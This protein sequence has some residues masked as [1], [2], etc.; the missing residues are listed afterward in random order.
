MWRILERI[1]NI[2]KAKTEK[3]LDKIE[4]PVEM[5]RLATIEFEQAINKSHKALAEVMADL[6]MKEKTLEQA[7]FTSESWWDKAKMAKK[8]GN[9]ELAAKALEQKA[10]SDTKVNEF[11]ALVL[12]LKQNVDLLKKQLEKNKLKLEEIRSKESI[13]AAKAE[14]AK[15][16]KQIAE[17]LGGLNNN[18]LSNLSKYEDQINKLEAKSNALTEL[19]EVNSKLEDEFIDLGRS[20]RVNSD[21]ELLNEELEKEEEQKRIKKEEISMKKIQ[22]SVPQKTIQI[23]ASPKIQ[24]PESSKEDKLNNL[25]NK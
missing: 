1:L 22:Q 10:I 2:F 13:Y 14:T 12:H 20:S 5:M 24:I 3:A 11:K 6:K 21:M 8:D 16:Q 15:A 19:N 18:A 23:H 4:D 7:V 9:E 17:S 25:F